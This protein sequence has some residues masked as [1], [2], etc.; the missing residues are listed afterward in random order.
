MQQQD[1]STRQ[2]F[3]DTDSVLQK[4][5]GNTPAVPFTEKV[6]GMFFSPVDGTGK[7]SAG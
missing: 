7:E 1:F 3:P 6:A 5:A 4:P 2:E